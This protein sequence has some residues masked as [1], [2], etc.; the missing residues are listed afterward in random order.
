DLTYKYSINKS[1]SHK[2]VVFSGASSHRVMY[3]GKFINR[4]FEPLKEGDNFLFLE[5]DSGSDPKIYSEDIIEVERLKKYYLL[6]HKFTRGNKK[7]TTPG[8]DDFNI[9]LKNNGL[10]DFILTREILY[11][12]YFPIYLYSEIY[13]DIFIKT[14]PKIVYGLCYYSP[15]MFGMFHAANKLKI[16]NYDIQHGAQGPLHSMYTF[17]N[18][19]STGL[20]TLPEKFWLWDE[21]SYNHIQKWLSG[22]VNHKAELRGNPW[23]NFVLNDNE[24]LIETTKKIILYTMQ[25]QSLDDYML[26]AIKNTPEEYQWWLRMHPRMKNEEYIYSQLQENNIENKVEINKANEYPLPEL[27][28]SCSIHISKFSGSIIEAELLNKHSL[29]LE[30]T[31]CN[32]YKE[33]IEKGNATGIL[34]PTPEEIIKNIL[35]QS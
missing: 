30:E 2:D 13:Y 20:N 27:L 17:A 25:S 4:Y 9:L 35:I 26:E 19:P 14:T 18:L 24:F 7:I 8:I 21:Y 3:D 29:I 32:V 34:N 5:Y 22:N 1:I 11:S 16:E 6:K 33:L 28:I 12:Y 15:A 10:E 23:Q 31:G